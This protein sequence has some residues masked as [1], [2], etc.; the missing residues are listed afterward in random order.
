MNH[1]LAGLLAVLF[2]VAA[3]RAEP[4]VT[5]PI[6]SGRILGFHLTTPGAAQRV[7]VRGMSRVE[8]RT[9]ATGY[10]RSD[11]AAREDGWIFVDPDREDRNWRFDLADGSHLRYASPPAARPLASVVLCTNHDMASADVLAAPLGSSQYVP[12][13]TLPDRPRAVLLRSLDDLPPLARALDRLDAVVLDTP[14]LSRRPRLQRAL[15]AYALD[16]GRVILSAEAQAGLATGDPLAGYLP[17]DRAG[18]LHAEAS[19]VADMAW[20]VVGA[21]HVVQ[22]PGGLP[23]D[24]AF[25]QRVRLNCLSRR[26]YPSLGQPVCAGRL[27]WMLNDHRRVP[28]S[29][30]AAY[31]LVYLVAI[32]PW[33]RRARSW[34]ATPLLA[35]GF[36]ALAAGLM[37]LCARHRRASFE[38]TVL[39]AESGSRYARVN[40]LLTLG[41]TRAEPAI[42]R[43]PPAGG[44]DPNTGGLGLHADA[45]G[46]VLGSLPVRANTS[47]D[48]STTRV[49]DVG[50]PVS[51]DL[52]LRQGCL[53]GTIA[54]RS[55]LALHGACVVWYNRGYLIGELPPGATHTLHARPAARS[56]DTED[57]LILWLASHSPSPTAR[58]LR[59]HPIPGLEPTEPRCARPM[60]YAWLDDDRRDPGSQ[61]WADDVFRLRLLAVRQCPREPATAWSSDYN[62]H[63]FAPT[64]EQPE[65]WTA[66]ALS[67]AA[68]GN[69]PLQ[70]EY[71]GADPYVW[72]PG[73]QCYARVRGRRP[74]G[75]WPQGERPRATAELSP[76]ERY[77]N[78]GQLVVVAP[79]ASDTSSVRARLRPPPEAATE[80]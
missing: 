45:R 75:P 19:A 39:A 30:L 20:R 65:H 29:V 64:A 5:L 42:L 2:G 7:A 15:A 48:I 14:G 40:T 69:Q 60:L 46:E 44:L 52:A 32:V 62:G 24:A 47:L 31:L 72:I 54:N 3:L 9:V 12:Y 61:G 38:A 35:F 73:E 80:R 10:T 18:R 23:R 77:L 37:A 63:G 70:L 8:P 50:G 6:G 78:H 17:R 33:R 56:F 67:V 55:R 68:G 36:V 53:A 1:A 59:P 25:W 51:L 66:R 21:G 16:G 22:L 57:D 26:Q 34:L 76:A 58:R 13:N 11:R 27:T 79:S 43:L 74:L 49:D 71:G 41:P 28:L 4:V